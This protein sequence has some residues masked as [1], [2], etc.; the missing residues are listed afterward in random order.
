MEET[1]Y[2][3]IA[4]IALIV[5][6]LFVGGLYYVISESNDRSVA[7]LLVK[8][9]LVAP[10]DEKIVLE[11]K[12]RDRIEKR[13]LAMTSRASIDS[14]EQLVNNAIAC[15]GYAAQATFNPRAEQ[16]D[17]GEA[18]KYCMDNPSVLNEIVE[19]PKTEN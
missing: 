12:I 5:V 3:S 1:N 14:F 9:Y 18:W 6:A 10:P 7:L 19:Y 13:P 2:T 17:A 4:V 15:E 11:G 16:K 8:E